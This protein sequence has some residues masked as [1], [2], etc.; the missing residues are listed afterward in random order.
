MVE[1]SSFRTTTV[2]IKVGMGLKWAESKKHAFVQWTHDLNPFEDRHPL[3]PISP[4]VLNQLSSNL[5]H[6]LF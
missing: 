2:G 1:I 3:V 5:E 6:K 4:Q